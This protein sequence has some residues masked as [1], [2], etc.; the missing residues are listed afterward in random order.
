MD[1]QQSMFILKKKVEALIQ[2]YSN[3]IMGINIFDN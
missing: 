3:D 2:G 1:N